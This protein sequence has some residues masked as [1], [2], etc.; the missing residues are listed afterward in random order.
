[1]DEPIRI[2]L[3]PASRSASGG[4]I[5]PELTGSDRH[6][7]D[8]LLGNIVNPNEV[9]PADY[10][11]TVFTL[12]DGRVVSGV[13]PE[14]N[15]RTVTVQTPVERLTIPADTITKRESL[16]VSLMPEG[17]L[18]TMDEA[19]VKDLVAYLMTRGPVAVK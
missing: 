14:Q 10:R 11:L 17:L 18:K 13:V 2:S 5:G 7:I 19:A 6:N 16:P 1:M 9:V 15:E 12:K 3:E 4:A 8:Y